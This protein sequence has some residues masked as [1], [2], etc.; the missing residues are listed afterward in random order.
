[1]FRAC[2]LVFLLSQDNAQRARTINCICLS[3][4]IQTATS[5]RRIF[6]RVMTIPAGRVKGVSKSRGSDH[7]VLK[8]HGSGRV[9]SRGF[10]ISWVG[11]GRVNRL[12]NLA[13]RVG[14]GKEVFKIS[15]VGSGHDP[16]DMGHSRVK[17][18]WPASCFRLSCGSNPRIWPADPPFSNLQLRANAMQAP[19]RSDLRNRKY[20]K[21][22]CSCLSRTDAP[23]TCHHSV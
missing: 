3:E 14:L 13:G 7:H 4:L 2:Y 9:G 6:R 19:R 21:T 5:L 16:R 17:P 22:Y 15:R 8:Y 12:Q 11:L 20:Y 23:I 18:S 1:M 10:K